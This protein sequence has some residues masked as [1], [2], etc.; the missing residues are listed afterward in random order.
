MAVPLALSVAVFVVDLRLPLGWSVWLLYVAPVLLATWA[1]QSR[2]VFLIAALCTAGVIV[3][4]FWSAPGGSREMA[5]FNRSLG[6]LMIWMTAFITFHHR[7]AI[8]ALRQAQAE[9]ERRIVERQ[10]Y[11]ERTNE[12]LQMERIEHMRTKAKLS[13]E[14]QQPA[15][16]QAVP[17]QERPAAWPAQAG[18]RHA[19]ILIIEDD[20]DTQTLLNRHLEQGGYETQVAG[21]GIEAL[22]CLGKRDFDLILSDITMPNLDGI[23]LLEMSKKKGITTPLIF[24]TTQFSKESEQRGLELGAADFLTK[25]IKRDMLLQRVKAALEKHEQEGTYRA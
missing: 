19:S 23:Q 1:S 12:I 11:L 4:F 14:A 2:F 24:L 13:E 18:S 9:L 6:T 5:I 8:M 10:V 21:D 16:S 15:Q 3:D 7:K 17:S 22:L 25:P 20:P